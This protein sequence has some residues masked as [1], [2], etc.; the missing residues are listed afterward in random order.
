MYYAFYTW[1]T[2]YYCMCNSKI[3]LTVD[4][5]SIFLRIAYSLRR[6]LSCYLKYTAPKNVPLPLKLIC[7]SG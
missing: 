4:V 7:T 2:V 1:L 5:T 6:Y 3:N